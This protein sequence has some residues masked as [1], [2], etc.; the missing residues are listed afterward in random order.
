MFRSVFLLILLLALVGCN[1]YQ[2]KEGEMPLGYNPVAFGS[3]IYDYEN[4]PLTKDGF[5]LGRALFYDPILSVDSTIACASCHQQFV[6]FAHADHILSHGFDGKTGIRNS[7]A[8]FNNRWYSTFF[9]DGGGNHIELV[10]MNAI[11]NPVEMNQ[12]LAAAVEKLNQNIRYSR[13]FK[14]AFNI[15]SINSKYL[16][17]ALAQFTGSII[18]ENSKYDQ[19]K[20]NE[21]TFSTGEERG[22]SLFLEHCADCHTEPLFTNNEYENNGLTINHFQDE[23]RKKVTTLDSDLGKFRIPTLRNIAI[24]Q[25]YMHDGR[26]STLTAVLEHYKNGIQSSPTLSPKLQNGISL[27]VTEQQELIAFLKTLTDETLRHDQRFANPF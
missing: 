18:S 10:P 5:E 1:D 12:D 22:Y 4:N 26:F 11:T 9:W 6:A 21:A 19:V 17:Y 20:E 7:P 27:T 8:I 14:K 23:G 15:E 2:L 16:F 25:P 24:T 13:W 3:P